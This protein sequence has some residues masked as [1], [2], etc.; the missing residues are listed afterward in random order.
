[1]T[2]ETLDTIETAAKAI[3]QEVDVLRQALFEAEP[4]Y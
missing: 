4:K 2:K 3:L 1:M